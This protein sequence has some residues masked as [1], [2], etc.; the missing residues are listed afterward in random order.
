MIT[1][2]DATSVNFQDKLTTVKAAEYLGLKPA[3]LNAWRSRKNNQ[4][5]Y[6]RIG[7]KIY[8]LREDLDHYIAGQRQM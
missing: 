3:T 6:Y 8:Y 4:I 7:N 5:P 2:T 1:V